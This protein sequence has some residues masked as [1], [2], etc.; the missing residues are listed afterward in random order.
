MTK[1]EAAS[2]RAIAKRAAAQVKANAKVADK[3]AKA[4]AKADA[5]QAKADKKA[6]RST[7]A[8]MSK[9]ASKEIPKA[10]PVFAP[11]PTDKVFA[12]VDAAP[13][14][15]KSTVTEV[16]PQNADNTEA[17]R[18]TPDPFNAD[19]KRMFN[20]DK[21]TNIRMAARHLHEL[22]LKVAAAAGTVDAGPVVREL[23]SS[24]RFGK[25]GIKAAKVEAA[26]A[27]KIRSRNLGS[28]SRGD[29]RNID[30]AEADRVRNLS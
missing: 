24:K 12:G 2:E 8:D 10:V 20:E 29:Q 15:E 17:L 11:A 13:K 21:Q 3:A 7:S 23:K 5:K 30:A 1:R 25:A 4:K 22:G 28:R 16:L 9:N 26:M 19:G 27:A 14:A 6:G 18:R